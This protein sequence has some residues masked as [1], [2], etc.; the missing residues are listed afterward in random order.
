MNPETDGIYDDLNS[1]TCGLRSDANWNR[2]SKGQKDIDILSLLQQGEY[3]NTFL[4]FHFRSRL[5]ANALLMYCLT[6]NMIYYV[7]GGHEKQGYIPKRSASAQ[8]D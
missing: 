2:G 7:G 4:F 5:T 1:S 8:A 3:V 6:G